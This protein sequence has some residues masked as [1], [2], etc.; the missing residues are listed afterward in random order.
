MLLGFGG[1]M[2]NE[3]F[4]GSKRAVFIILFKKIVA[5]FKKEH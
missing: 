1:I 5:F 4:K 3:G 2:F